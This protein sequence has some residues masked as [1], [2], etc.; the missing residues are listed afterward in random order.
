MSNKKQTVLL[1]GVFLLALGLRLNRIYPEFSSSDMITAVE[2]ALDAIPD[3]FNFRSFLDFNRKASN[4]LRML[5]DKYSPLAVIFTSLSA[6]LFSILGLRI[7]ELAWLLP[8]ILAGAVTPVAVFLL[9]KQVSGLAPAIISAMTISLLPIHVMESRLIT[10]AEVMGF[11]GQVLTLY[12]L[13]AYLKQPSRRNALYFGTVLG[14]YF[15]THLKWPGILPVI[16]YVA[17]VWAGTGEESVALK[18]RRASRLLLRPAV[19]ML[20][21]LALG[22]LVASSVVAGS[23][24][25]VLINGPLGHFLTRTGGGRL[26][27]YINYYYPYALS[28]AGGLLALLMTA[29]F[30]LGLGQVIHL[31]KVSI[32]WVWGLCYSLP[33]WIFIGPKTTLPP[34]YYSSGLQAFAI[35]TVVWL[36]V[37]VGQR[38]YARRWIYGLLTLSLTF[39]LYTVFCTAYSFQSI[40]VFHLRGWQGCYEPSLGM[41]AAGYWLRNNTSVEA[42]VFAFNVGGGGMEPSNCIYYFNRVVMS[43]Y[44]SPSYEF[45]HSYYA[46]F[47]SEMDYFIISPADYNRM[48][49]SSRSRIPH[50][51]AR[52][53]DHAGKTLLL[54]YSK[55]WLGPT[56][57]LDQQEMD[58]AFD[59]EFGRLA[60][61]NSEYKLGKK[62]LNPYNEYYWDSYNVS[63]K[64]GQK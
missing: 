27:L 9:V 56:V 7:T 64:S 17:M 10:P 43:L 57:S 34:T 60:A 44:D 16:V 61:L 42:K 8:T 31:T 63:I 49:E 14:A 50:L 22:V 41:K 48:A 35:F 23:R 12:F 1:A 2:R 38:L 40:N 30:F 33:Y 15:Y 11:L 37:V 32:F 20:P 19:W 62:L 52:V 18:A 36:I 39:S 58:R 6:V 54:I 26:G 59:K 53:T 25:D 13:I 29:A 46:R 47:A 5:T 24:N 21:L 28:F 51:A 45:T 3:T 55:R 4:P